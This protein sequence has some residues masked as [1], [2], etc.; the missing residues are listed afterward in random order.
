M[1]RPVRTGSSRLP[2]SFW[3]VP[4]EWI[5]PARSGAR[6]RQTRAALSV[7]AGRRHHPPHEQVFAREFALWDASPEA[8]LIAA[9]TFGVGVSGIAA[10][11]AIA[12]MMVS[13]RWIPFESQDEGMLLHALTKRDSIF[14]KGLRYNLPPTQLMASVVLTRDGGQPIARPSN[15]LSRRAGWI[16]G[17][18]TLRRDQCLIF[19][20]KRCLESRPQ[21]T[22]S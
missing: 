6:D 22:A 7:H 16:P 8:H 12:L 18:G 2:A 3:P 17:Y 20:C 4:V 10:I 5:Q 15:C 19:L 1:R 14:V 9:A 13:E 11:K 21:W